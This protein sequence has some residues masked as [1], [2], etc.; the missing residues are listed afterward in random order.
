MTTHFEAAMRRLKHGLSEVYSE[1]ERIERGAH[2]EM[3]PPPSGIS[4]LVQIAVGPGQLAGW[5]AQSMMHAFVIDQIK[6]E[7][8]TDFCALGYP[9]GNPVECTLVRL[10]SM[11]GGGGLVLHPLQL[12]LLG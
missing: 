4:P 6:R 12:H 9:D 11:Q 5:R 1:V 7:R 10:P 3:I 2:P 8:I